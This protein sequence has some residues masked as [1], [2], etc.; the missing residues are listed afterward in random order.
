M[1]I[2][3]ISQQYTIGGGEIVSCRLASELSGLGKDVLYITGNPDMGE[4]ELPIDLIRFHQN[5][6]KRFLSRYLV[7]SSFLY[8]HW[9]HNI[10][11]NEIDTILATVRPDIINIHGL[12]SVH[13]S[14][15]FIEKCLSYGPVVWTLHDMISFTGQCGHAYD[16]RQ[17]LTG[18]NTTCPD[19]HIPLLIPKRYTKKIY[20]SRKDLFLTSPNL[21]AIV[22]SRWLADCA[23]QGLWRGHRISVIPNGIPLDIFHPMKKEIARE[24]LSLSPDETILMTSAANLSKKGKGSDILIEAL[25]KITHPL[26]ILTMGKGTIHLN[27]PVVKV[28]PFGYVRDE[29]K[30]ILLY[31]A[32]DIFIHPSEAENLPTVIME[33]LAC[34]TPVIAFPVGGVP[35][36]VIPQKT[37]WIS[38]EISAE[39]LA[40]TINEAIT[41]IK[42]EEVRFDCRRIAEEN[43]DLK[44]QAE[45]YYQFFSEV[46]GLP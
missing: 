14:V 31:N 18:C 42:K 7:K 2:A 34:N 19:L 1:N 38:N 10:L 25:E 21:Y 23:I 9:G 32:A 28:I 8:Y 30:K 11:T 12:S 26:T 6:L 27:N 4:E 45:R 13:Y 37:G 46:S 17:Y 24:K 5:P 15:S 3:I 16:C 43:Y 29:E 40:R 44:Q 41:E 35:E 36:M 20:Q 39:S 33:S 22:P